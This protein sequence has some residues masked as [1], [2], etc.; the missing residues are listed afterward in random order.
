MGKGVDFKNTSLFNKVLL[1]FYPM[2]FSLTPVV[3]ASFIFALIKYIKKPD[4]YRRLVFSLAVFI[5]LLFSAT[6]YIH[7][8]AIIRYSIMLYPLIFI[9]AAIGA[10]GVFSMPG[11]K[12]INKH[13]VTGLIIAVSILSLWSA[14][15]FYLNYTNDLLPKKHLIS[16]AWGY[17]GYEAAQYLNAQPEAENLV[18]WTDQNGYCT[19][20]KGKC[21]RGSQDWKDNK[22]KG[23]LQVDYFIKTRRGSIMYES[24]WDDLKKSTAVDPHGAVWQMVINGRPG[25]YVMIFKNQLK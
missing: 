20:F 4:R 22:A 21:M 3:L 9:I 6:I 15:P 24:I 13:L 16:D 5:I 23:G 8:L 7:L 17:G 2:V 1:E 11:L 25:N 18:V 10:Y 19:F 14:K 12:R